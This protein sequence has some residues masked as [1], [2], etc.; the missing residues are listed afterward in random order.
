MTTEVK[1]KPAQEVTIAEA[2]KCLGMSIDTY[3]DVSLKRIKC[4]KV[5]SPT[6]KYIW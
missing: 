6:V 3:A 5:P 2:A 1:N 4:H